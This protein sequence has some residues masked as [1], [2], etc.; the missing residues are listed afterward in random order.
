MNNYY[1]KGGPYS[2]FT[3]YR[4][5]KRSRLTINKNL[6]NSDTI[7]C[8]TDMKSKRN[9]CYIIDDF[10]E[11][12][13]Q[14]TECLKT[15]SWTED[16]IYNWP[17]VPEKYFK[18]LNDYEVDVIKDNL[19]VSDKRDYSSFESRCEDLKRFKKIYR[20]CCTS[21]LV[22]EDLVKDGLFESSE[23]AQG[24][25]SWVERTRY[26]FNKIAP[27]E[28]WE[29]YGNDYEMGLISEKDINEYFAL[30]EI[31]FIFH[32]NLSHYFDI[33]SGSDRKYLQ[34]ML[35]EADIEAYSEGL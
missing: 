26:H 20:H 19:R 24:F 4:T 6:L 2:E 13:L 12:L 35:E 30:R 31:G 22:R 14:N 8:F 27:S 17:Y 11:W 7:V 23:Q 18:F 1:K 10:Y 16:G 15:K 29:D 32:E 21:N 28:G 5:L 9:F 33:R 34:D 25:L 3:D